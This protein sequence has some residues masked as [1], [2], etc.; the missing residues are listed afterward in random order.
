VQFV[1]STHFTGEKRC[2]AFYYAKEWNGA[3]VQECNGA[4][5]RPHALHT[6][7]Q[8]GGRASPWDT[9]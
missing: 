5:G 7:F 3:F 4:G 8:T 1:E 9:T 6:F 2:P